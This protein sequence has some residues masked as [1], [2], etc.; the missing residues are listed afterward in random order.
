MLIKHQK[1]SKNM[2]KNSLIYNDNKTI[3]VHK[4]KTKNSNKQRAEEQLFGKSEPF[5]HPKGKYYGSIKCYTLFKEVQIKDLGTN[6]EQS[7][8]L[9]D[10]STTTENCLMDLSRTT[11]STTSKPCKKT[12][13]RIMTTDL[14]VTGA[15]SRPDFKLSATDTHL[16]NHWHCK[17]PDNGC[18]IPLCQHCA[19]GA[20]VCNFSFIFFGFRVFLI[21]KL[22][23]F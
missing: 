7:A 21:Q 22:S 6:L 10:L 11:Q 23:E 8:Y 19:D 15:L 12:P 3:Y 13:Q 5:V 17:C 9:M 1:V 18:K 2:Q 4:R 20:Q 14:Q 16:I